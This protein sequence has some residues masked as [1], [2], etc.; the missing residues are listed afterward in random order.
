MCY[1][2]KNTLHTKC[3]LYTNNIYK[4]LYIK[5]TQKG[6]HKTQRIICSKIRNNIYKINSLL[7]LN[8]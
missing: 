7:L 1:I 2:Q 6:I 5:Y 3:I 8:F 4:R